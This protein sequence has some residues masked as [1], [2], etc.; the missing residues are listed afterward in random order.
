ML[1]SQ[2]LVLNVVGTLCVNQS[3]SSETY[4]NSMDFVSF[5]Q[6]ADLLLYTVLPL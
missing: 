1:Q 4:V 2:V 3:S 5:V 6:F